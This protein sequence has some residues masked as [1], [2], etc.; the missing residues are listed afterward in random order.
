ME[1]LIHTLETIR[2]TISV[3][4]GEHGTVRMLLYQ[5]L[6]KMDSS[7]ACIKKDLQCA[8][9]LG[10]F[11][12][13]ITLNCGHSYCKECLLSMERSFPRPL[14]P[15]CRSPFNEVYQMHE[16]KSLKSLASYMTPK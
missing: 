7:N 12:S 9:H 8:I 15:E 10:V 1:W 4:A 2:D 11:V 14:C 13:P 6:Q 16:N 5:I 3:D